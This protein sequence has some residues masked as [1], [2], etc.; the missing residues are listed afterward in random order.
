MGQGRQR[1]VGGGTPLPASLPQCYRINLDWV[2]LLSRWSHIG[3]QR[4][5]FRPKFL[6]GNEKEDQARKAGTPDF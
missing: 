1:G 5:T 2:Q 3:H 6:G 4:E